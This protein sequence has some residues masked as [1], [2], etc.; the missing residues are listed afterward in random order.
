LCNKCFSCSSIIGPMLPRPDQL[1]WARGNTAQILSG[2]QCQKGFIYS[3]RYGL[4]ELTFF[5]K[6]WK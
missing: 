6:Y 4:N 2:I 5:F 1:A 3:S